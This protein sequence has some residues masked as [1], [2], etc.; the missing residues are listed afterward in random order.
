MSL[1]LVLFALQD[2]IN[3]LIE[4]VIGQIGLDGIPFDTLIA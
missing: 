2:L 3:H 4:L 1:L